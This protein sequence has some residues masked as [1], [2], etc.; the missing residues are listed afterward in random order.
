MT[1]LSD[2]VLGSYFDYRIWLTSLCSLLFSSILF[3]ALHR[4]Q[5][6]RVPCPS[7]TPRVFSNS[8]PLT[9]G[10]HPTISSSGAPFSYLSFPPWESFPMGW[11][12]TSGGQNTGALAS[13][14]ALPMNIQNWFPLGLTG[15]ISLQSKRLP[16]VFS[17]TTVWKHQFFSAQSSLWSNANIRTWLLEK[18]YVWL[19]GHLSEN[20]CLC[21]LICCLAL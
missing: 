12:F 4:L 13:T 21:I 7:L 17:S 16:R 20:W 8:C 11:L 18:P 15:L 9:Q 14:S 3:F 19:Y 2:K 1:S 5:H 10:C 6:T